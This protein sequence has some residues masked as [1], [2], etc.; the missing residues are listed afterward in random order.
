MQLIG[1]TS[2]SYPW[3]TYEVLEL[4]GCFFCLHDALHLALL[5]C[6][7]AGTD[8]HGT[9]SHTE[10]RPNNGGCFFLGG[11]SLEWKVELKSIVV[12]EDEDDR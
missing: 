2:I 4:L 7:H 1:S 8:C 6:S 10:G 11:R 5:A 9:T 3:R 12:E